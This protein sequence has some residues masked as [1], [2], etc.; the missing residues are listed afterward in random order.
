MAAVFAATAGGFLS[1][2]A[3]HA[4]DRAGEATLEGA[5]SRGKRKTLRRTG[6]TLEHAHHQGQQEE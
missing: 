1:Q 2:I 5:A 3:S 4:Q 6:G